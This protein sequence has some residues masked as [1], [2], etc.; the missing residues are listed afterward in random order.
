MVHI[1]TRA[2]AIAEMVVPWKRFIIKMIYEKSLMKEKDRQVERRGLGKIW[3]G[4][5]GLALQE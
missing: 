5:K 2:E 1:Y 3:R 4:V